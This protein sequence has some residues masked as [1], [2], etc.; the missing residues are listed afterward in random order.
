[1]GLT[2]IA[3]IFGAA[4]EGANIGT[5]TQSVLGH[6]FSEDARH[7]N[8]TSIASQNRY[9][10]L[11]EKIANNSANLNSKILTAD[12]IAN[13]VK[14]YTMT[15]RNGSQIWVMAKDGKIFNAGINLM[16]K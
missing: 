14:G 6:I 12:A 1:V 16:P 15:F 10:K 9:I 4:E 13:G 7:L 2:G 5:K 11:F 8:V 3:S